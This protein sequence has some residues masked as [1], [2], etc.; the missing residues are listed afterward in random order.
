MGR[1]LGSGRSRPPSLI[2]FLVAVAFVF[3]G[4]Y[5]FTG[6]QSFL[7]TGG[8]GVEESTRQAG[9]VETATAARVTR[10]VPAAQFTLR[11]TATPP[12]PCQ[13]F[14]VDVPEGIVREGPSTTAKI[15]TQLSQ[16]TIVCVLGR[17][18]GSEWYTLDMNPSTRR[19]DLAYMHESVIEAVNPT[20]T[21]TSTPRA[22]ATPEPPR[23]TVTPSPVPTIDMTLENAQERLPSMPPPALATVTLTPESP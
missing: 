6:F 2:V 3:G 21:P 16:G 7:R 23:E 18:T 22:S 13:D 20:L 12:P 15:V 5:L 9:I 4:Y 11:P 19:I 17:E 14:R 10:I 1:S 8:L